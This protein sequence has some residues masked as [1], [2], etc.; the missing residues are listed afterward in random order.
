VPL[1]QL[2]LAQNVEDLH[3]QSLQDD[4]QLPV[5]RGA[6]VSLPKREHFHVRQDE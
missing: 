6:F 4:L 2:L 1:Q 3:H 5:L